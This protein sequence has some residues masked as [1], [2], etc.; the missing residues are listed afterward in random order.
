LFFIEFLLLFRAT[1][2]VVQTAK[3]VNPLRWFRVDIV[4]RA[5]TASCPM[6]TAHAASRSTSRSSITETLGQPVPWPLL[7]LVNIYIVRTA[8]VYILLYN[9]HDSGLCLYICTDPHITSLWATHNAQGLSIFKKKR[10]NNFRI[11]FLE[12][13]SIS[14]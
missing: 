14:N 4:N 12:F 11:W 9:S 2:A 10:W 13:R 6:R 1:T 7:Y 5:Q 8:A 3:N